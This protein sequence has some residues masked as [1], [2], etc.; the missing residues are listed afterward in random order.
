M[1]IEEL[2]EKIPLPSQNTVGVCNQITLLTLYCISSRLV[3]LLKSIDAPLQVSDF[4]IL[5]LVSSSL[6]LAF[7]YSFFLFLKGLLVLL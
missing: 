5:F 1:C 3:T 2:I 6:I 4:L 7:R